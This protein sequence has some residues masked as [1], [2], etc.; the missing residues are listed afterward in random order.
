MTDRLGL[1]RKCDDKAEFRFCAC[2]P[3]ESEVC[4]IQ[5]EV[6]ENGTTRKFNEMRKVTGLP[7]PHGP[8]NHSAAPTTISKGLAIDNLLCHL[9]NNM[10]CDQAMAHQQSM[11]MN[12]VE[13]QKYPLHLINWL[14]LL[15]YGLDVHMA[16]QE[17]PIWNPRKRSVKT[18]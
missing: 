16:K 1:G 2:H 4:S 14:V 9:A 7:I 15:A 8:K 5:M 13:N 12:D 11:E 17:Q 18:E 10:S 3:V 6:N